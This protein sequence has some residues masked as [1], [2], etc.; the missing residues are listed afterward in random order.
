MYPER[1]DK[2]P[3]PGSP[4]DPENIRGPGETTKS[5][6]ALDPVAR[7]RR[8]GSRDRRSTTGTAVIRG[9]GSKLCSTSSMISNFS[10]AEYLMKRPPYPRERFF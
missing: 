6:V 7:W 3:R 1:D 10:D 2:E 9:A 4:H 8:S 5:V